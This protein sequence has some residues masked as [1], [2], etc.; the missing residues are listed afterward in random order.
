MVYLKIGLIVLYLLTAYDYYLERL[1]AMAWG[2]PSVL[3]LGVFAVLS[4]ALLLGAFTRQRWLR[5]AYALMFFVAA[6]FF[7]AYRHIT[8]DYLNYSGFVSLLHSQ[9]FIG[10]AW[11]QFSASILPAI[12]R[13]LLLLFGI[14][15]SPSA[16]ATRRLPR[17]LS[18]A[19]PVLGIALLSTILFVRGGEGARG[20][21]MMFTPP[22]YLSMYAYEALNDTVGPRQPVMLARGSKAIDYSIVLIIDESVSG[23]YLDINAEHGVHSGLK[24]PP[25]GVAVYNYGYA[26]S[27]ANCS[28]DTNIT[29]RYGGTR[30]DY[31]RI[32]STL[33]SIWQY[34]RQAGLR[35]V[36]IDAQRTGGGLQNLMTRD[37]ARQID[38]F[39]QFDDTAIRDRDMAVAA[40][41]VELLADEVPSLVIVNKIGAHFPV[42]DKYPDAF[43][44]YVPALPRG[45]YT[46][47][48][49]TGDRSGFDGSP[50]DWQ[51]YRNAYK[52]TLLWNIGEFFNR[53]LSQA[54]LSKAVLLYT[55]D[56]G[57]DLH[58][59]GNPGLN[60]HCSSEPVLEEGLVPLVVIQ[61]EGLNSLDW[62]RELEANRNRSS[63]YNLFPTLLQLMDY[64]PAEVQQIYGRSLLVR[65]E[66]PFTFNTR[67]NARLGEKPQW[68]HIDV[69]Q[70]VLPDA[71][72]AV[73]T[74][75][76]QPSGE[77]PRTP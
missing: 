41:L 28:A 18:A 77:A 44:R 54:D 19:A 4:A 32:N 56:H 35:T 26:A 74:Q 5:Y 33:P 67:F 62:Q 59:R 1:Q 21:P 42:H 38:Q 27:I 37:E 46:D 68:K 63:H 17:G 2:L 20:L 22:S 43:T 7:D 34:A 51:R 64:D 10:D 76:A 25:P 16:A 30:D 8:A 65:T 69:Q 50:E 36:Y 3:Y 66:D 15:L 40:R 73:I 12:G 53:L 24:Q 11:E 13:G 9:A 31:L 49:D 58:E 75:T 61:G 14:A 72:P 45:R 47:I 23:N 70:V 48:S 52:N 55:A 57:Q 29:L 6:V 71:S 39:I 60:T